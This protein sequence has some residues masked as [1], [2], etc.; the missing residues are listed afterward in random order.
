MTLR[1][2]R[3]PSRAQ[4]TAA[5]AALAAAPLLLAGAPSPQA[6]PRPREKDPFRAYQA[7]LYDQALQGFVDAQVERPEDPRLAL[8]VGSA[9]YQMRNFKDAGTAYG[10]A[11]A[12]TQ[13][14]K[15]RAQALYNLGNVAYR[16]GQLEE[17]VK[18]YQAALELNPDD[19]DAK[20]NLEF[21]RNE[22]RRRHEE[23]KKRQEEQKGQ[24]GQEGQQGEQGQQGQEGQQGQQGQEKG[25]QQPAPGEDEKGNA[26]T[27]READEAGQGE[28]AMSKEEAERVLAALS[29]ARPDHQGDKA[30]R[31]RKVRGGKDW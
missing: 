15:L 28:R 17:A 7:G 30:Q 31:G 26:V 4:W 29:E 18:L 19:E 25:E 16:E 3:R 6:A 20:F 12:K 14:P 1:L 24:Q 23:A 9:H 10:Q 2:R 11:A 13:D 8:N 21:V 27:E 5:L 22:I